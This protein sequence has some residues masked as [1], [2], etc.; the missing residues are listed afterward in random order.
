MCHNGGI[1]LVHNR[2]A[3]TTNASQ[4]ASYNASSLFGHDRTFYYNTAGITWNV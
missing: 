1:S 4:T 3:D 2:A